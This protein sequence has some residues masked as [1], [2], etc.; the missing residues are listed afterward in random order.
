MTPSFV[1]R[2]APSIQ[3]SWF[4]RALVLACALGTAGGCKTIEQHPPS[5]DTKPDASGD[6]AKDPYP[7]VE[8][9]F[10]DRRL[11]ISPGNTREVKLRV[12]PPDVYPVRIALFGDALGAYADSSQL[13]TDELGRASVNLTVPLDSKELTLRASVGNHHGDLPVSVTPDASGTLRIVPQYSGSRPIENWAVSIQNDVPCVGLPLYEERYGPV[14]KRAPLT[15]TVAA[16]RTITLII[17]G[18]EYVFGCREGIFVNASDDQEV[19]VA[20]TDRP[21]QLNTLE[22][23]LSLG[24]EASESF[25][26]QLG[27]LTGR[28]LAAFRGGHAQDVDALLGRMAELSQSDSAFE[29]SSAAEDWRGQLI[30]SLTP[31]GAESGLSSYVQLWLSSG[32]HQLFTPDTV[33][34]QLKGNIQPTSRA[35]FLVDDVVGFAPRSVGI[36][37]SFVLSMATAPVDKLQFEFDFVWQ[38]AK[39]LGQLAQSAALNSTVTDGGVQLPSGDAGVGID[40]APDVLAEGILHCGSLGALLSGPD[41]SAFEGCDQTCLAELCRNAIDSMWQDTL[42]AD[43]SPASIAITIARP[44][45]LDTQARPIGFEGEWVGEAKL[46]NEPPVDVAGPISAGPADYDTP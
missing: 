25:T 36:P 9:D 27:D 34:G 29:A 7:G 13:Q 3:S 16:N 18:E 6:D 23:S 46:G 1:P 24:F 28:M 5:I 38:P 39:L 21:I 17:R 31:R 45:M 15:A 20:V 4:G 42:D 2:P 19:T 8:I 11:E 32:L 44:A 12:S 22:T 30:Q 35:L 41:G 26:A 43:H 14:Q 10:E 33:R 37:D 40:T